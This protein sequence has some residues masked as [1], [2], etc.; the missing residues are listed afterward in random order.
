MPPSTQRAQPAKSLSRRVVRHVLQRARE[1]PHDV[2]RK[3]A[4][5]VADTVGIALAAR[6][7]ELVASVARAFAV[8]SHGGECTVLGNAERAAPQVAAFRN[9]AL[10]HLLDFDDILDAGRVHLTSV[11]LPA[12]LACAQLVEAGHAHVV[13][14]TACGNE[15]ICRLA[16]MYSPTGESPGSEWFLTQLFGYFGAALTAGLALGLAEDE[17]VSALGLA[18]MQA[19]GGKEAAAGV[20]ANARGIYP[21]FAAM[22]GVA[23]ALLARAGVRGPESALDGESNLF[24]TYF[25]ADPAPDAIEALLEIDDWRV[26]ESEPKLYPSCRLS[27]PYVDA[28]L[29]LRNEIGDARIER[30]TA[31]VNASA[32]RLCRPLEQRRH[33][34]TLQDAKYSIPFMIAFALCRGRVDLLSLDERALSDPAVLELASRVTVDE[35]LPDR[36][37]QPPAE[38]LVQS[39]KGV[40][41]RASLDHAP[42]TPVQLRQKFVACLAHAGMEGAAAALWKGLLDPAQ[43]LCSLLARAS[44]AGSV[45]VVRRPRWL[46]GALIRVPKA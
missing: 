40:H 4:L 7:A 43:D 15:L 2:R 19:A 30:V 11:T 38:I 21:A 36:P 46:D 32:A 1:I 20:G 12:A 25:G 22:G 29:A 17:L 39:D 34:M 45:G 10:A 44:G 37:G 13:D 31:A 3:T 6:N 5:H 23:A 14:A 42:V 41:E 33:P 35:R 24:R 28:A 26:R 27:H 8:G 18:Y 16:L 9:A